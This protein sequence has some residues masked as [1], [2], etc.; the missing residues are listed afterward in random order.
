MATRS[1]RL[2][3]GRLIYDAYRDAQG[4][5]KYLEY[6]DTRTGAKRLAYGPYWDGRDRSISLG[7]CATIKDVAETIQYFLERHQM[8]WMPDLRNPKLVRF[9]LAFSRLFPTVGDQ[10]ESMETGQIYTVIHV[11]KSFQGYPWNLNVLL[12]VAP[13]LGED[14]RWVG[15]ARDRNLVSFNDQLGNPDTPTPGENTGGDVGVAYKAPLHP[16]ITY[17]LLR[18]EAFTLGGTPFGPSKELVPRIRE[19]FPHPKIPQ[20]TISIL[21][22][23]MESLFEF[24]CTH[25]RAETANALADWFTGVISRQRPSLEANGINR[26]LFWSQGTPKR[27][28]QQGDES[29]VTE[30]TYY[31]VTEE[32]TVQEDSTIRKINVTL[33]PAMRQVSDLDLSGDLSSSEEGYLYPYTGAYDESGNYLWGDLEI[34]DNQQTGV[35][36]L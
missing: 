36:G 22:Q 5:V 13:T 20:R 4:N 19:Q 27:K 10:L 3:S 26:I 9:G 34:Q 16:T 14:L 15:D 23:R 12:D 6:F 24:S 18:K 25:T 8:T 30:V 35:T 1:R 33:T 7:N 29:A 32:L 28:G 11:P 17:L 2:P 31:I 21:G